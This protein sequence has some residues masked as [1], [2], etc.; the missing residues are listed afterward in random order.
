M[1][2]NGNKKGLRRDVRREGKA[3]REIKEQNGGRER[4]IKGEREKGRT[5]ES[6]ML[7]AWKEEEYTLEYVKDKKVN[8]H[9]YLLK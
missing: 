4:L 1:L 2:I 8:F 6:F 3:N 5:R 9:L 7:L